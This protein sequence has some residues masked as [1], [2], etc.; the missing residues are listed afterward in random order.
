MESTPRKLLV[1]SGR[2]TYGRHAYGAGAPEVARH[3]LVVLPRDGG[4]GTA[5][6]G[7]ID[8]HVGVVI[9]TDHDLR[10]IELELDAFGRPGGDCEE[11][12]H[13]TVVA[14]GCVSTGSGLPME[15]STNIVRSASRPEGLRFSV[16][17][18]S[19]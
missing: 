8:R 1:G 7:V 4:V 18:I 10:S 15:P 2:L 5:R 3:E 12:V 6:E 11:R 14:T 19:P 17:S 16:T 13:P 9:T